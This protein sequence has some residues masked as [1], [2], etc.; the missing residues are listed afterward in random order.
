MI[1]GSLISDKVPS[2]KSTDSAWSVLGW[3]SEFKIYQLPIVDDGH[4]VG[5]VSEDDILDASDLM[6]TI[7][8]IPLTTKER[9]S[10]HEQSHI[11]EVISMMNNFQLEILPVLSEERDYLGVITLRDIVS[12]LGTLFSLQEPGGIIILEIPQNGYM[13]S[14]IGRITESENAKILSL[15]ISQAPNSQSYYATLKV[16]VEDLTRLVASFNRFEYNIIKTFFR[17]DQLQNY[18]RNLDALMNYLDI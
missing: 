2:V 4:Y 15:Y 13:L 12:Q 16:N 8:E 1:A 18:Q 17:V 5:M 7:G 6:H 11:Y 14:E 3:M 10:I 9:A